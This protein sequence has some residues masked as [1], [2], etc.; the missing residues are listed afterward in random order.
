MTQIPLP[1]DWQVIILLYH[2][3]FLRSKS[4]LYQRSL[5]PRSQALQ[6]PSLLTLHPASH[7]PRKRFIWIENWPSLSVSSS[8]DP[9]ISTTFRSIFGRIPTPRALALG[10][11]RIPTTTSCLPVCWK[12]TA[13]SKIPIVCSAP[14]PSSR[15]PSIPFAWDKCAFSFSLWVLVE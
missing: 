15:E 2:Y 6:N 13:T 4:Y 1:R 12:S 14:S 10:C 9:H 5:L 3:Q 8:K 11:S 7:L